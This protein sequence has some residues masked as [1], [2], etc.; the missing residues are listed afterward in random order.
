MHVT[1]LKTLTY[2]GVDYEPGE[3]V[4]IENQ[5]SAE[6]LIAIEVAVEMGVVS[7]K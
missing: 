3:V 5:D 2:A 6:W 4:N 1:L 7:K